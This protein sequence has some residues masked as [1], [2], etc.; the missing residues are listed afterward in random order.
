MAWI[1]VTVAL[2][3]WISEAFAE[4]KKDTADATCQNYDEVI[5]KNLRRFKE[6]QK[7]VAVL[8]ETMSNYGEICF[9]E[10]SY[11]YCAELGNKSCKYVVDLRNE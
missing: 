6:D 5:L 2:V 11:P 4:I 10:K 1:I 7:Q 3:W 8:A 9:F